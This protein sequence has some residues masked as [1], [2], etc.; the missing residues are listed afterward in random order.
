MSDLHR[1]HVKFPHDLMIRAAAQADAEGVTL[2]RLVRRA[3][4]EYLHTRRPESVSN[5]DY[6]EGTP[7][8]GV[9]RASVDADPGADQQPLGGRR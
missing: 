6:D 7:Q 5:S 9:L 4:T 1:V 2:G 8:N 3:I